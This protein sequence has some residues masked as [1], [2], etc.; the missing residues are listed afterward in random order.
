MVKISIICCL[1]L[2]GKS[3]NQ[4]RKTKGKG[5]EDRGRVGE[6]GSGREDVV[7]RSCEGKRKGDECRGKG[8]EGRKSG[9]GRGGKVEKQEKSQHL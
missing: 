1:F 3:H 9:T 4:Q 6:T 7:Q 5:E 2:R 8:E